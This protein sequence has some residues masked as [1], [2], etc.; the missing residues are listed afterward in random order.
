MARKPTKE[1]TTAR[2]GGREGRREEETA[3][4]LENVAKHFCP[5]VA[6]VVFKLITRE[7]ATIPT[8]ARSPTSCWATP[9]MKRVACDS[10][11]QFAR[12]NGDVPL[13]YLSCSYTNGARNKSPA[14]PTIRLEVHPIPGAADSGAG[15]GRG[16]AN[17]QFKPTSLPRPL[18][19]FRP[20]H[21]IGSSTDF[22]GRHETCCAGRRSGATRAFVLNGTRG[23]ASPLSL[24][25]ARCNFEGP[26]WM[27][28]A[29]AAA[30]ALCSLFVAPSP[31]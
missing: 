20:L 23:L 13:R 16:E 31:S 14:R 27:H 4:K 18:A 6:I 9:R 22:C 25:S 28:A 7:A 10:S 2:K 30:A 19:N 3:V 24:A 15:R 5:F 17:F 8:L 26:I 29:A 1:R 21:K 12:G 11:G